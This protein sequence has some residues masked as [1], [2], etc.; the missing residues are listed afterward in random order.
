[1]DREGGRE[2]EEEE[3]EEKEE[4]EEG[5]EPPLVPELEVGRDGH[6]CFGARWLEC[7]ICKPCS[8]SCDLFLAPAGVPACVQ[9]NRRLSG[10]GGLEEWAGTGATKCL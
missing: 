7:E 9:G 2:E 10:T 1:M 6:E 5:R 4:E 3:E 8:A